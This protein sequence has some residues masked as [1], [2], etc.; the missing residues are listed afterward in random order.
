MATQFNFTISTDVIGGEV[1]AGR[2]E[3]EIRQ[4]AISAAL[5][6]VDINGTD[7]LVIEFKTDLTA[8]EETILHGDTTGPAGGLVGN[9]VATPLEEVTTVHLD[10]PTDDDNKPVIVLNPSPEKL[11]TYFTSRGDV[12]GPPIQRGEGDPILVEFETGVGVWPQT[13]SCTWKYAEPVWVHDGQCTWTTPTAFNAKDHFSLSVNIPATVATVNGG[14]TGNCN[15]VPTG[16]GY[17]VIVPA[18]G[19]GGHD[20][21]LNVAS[22][23]PAGR[24]KDGYWE[25]DEFSETITPST[26]PGA[27]SWHLLDIP[28]KSY[29]IRCLSMSDPRG[30]FDIDAYKTY[31]VPSAWTWELEVT[32]QEDGDGLVSGW[33]LIFRT[34][35]N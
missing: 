18:A 11:F 35:S 3:E 20:V 16:L 22:P 2:L 26:T 34:Q 31:W 7:S 24:S 33:L 5:D 8:G 6:G 1:D 19:N 28:I 29:F 15:V 17:N 21:D 32:K 4:S 27:S 30:V 12:A 25:V 14:G 23:V 13:K 9:H 10:A